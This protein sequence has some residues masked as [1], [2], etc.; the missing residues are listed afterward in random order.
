MSQRTTVF[1]NPVIDDTDST[2][3]ISVAEYSAAEV[4]RQFLA[5]YAC[6]DFKAE[7]EE[8][9]VKPFQFLRRTK[10]LRELRALCI[11][12]WGLALQKSFPNNAREFFEEFRASAPMLSGKDKESLELANRINIYIDLFNP[13]KDTDFLPVADYLAEV[14]ALDATDRA[15]LRLKLSLIIRNLYTLIFNKLV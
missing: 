15:R 3:R 4:I 11:A 8:I 9:G 13:K 14:L 10:I 7:L 6:L 5:L 12:L 1:F 2:A